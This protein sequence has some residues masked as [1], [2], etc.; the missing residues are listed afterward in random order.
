MNVPFPDRRPGPRTRTS[1][2]DESFS[3]DEMIALRALIR[4][5]RYR[6]F[7]INKDIVVTMDFD[8]AVLLGQVLAQCYKG[9][10]K[11]IQ[12]FAEDLLRLEGGEQLDAEYGG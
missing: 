11:A 2:P 10:N 12:K 7:K 4:Q 3:S 6:K 5:F 1:T 9:D 8:F